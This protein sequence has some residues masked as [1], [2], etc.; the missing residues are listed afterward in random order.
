MFDHVSATFRHSIPPS[1]KHIR[2]PDDDDAASS[3]DSSTHDEDDHRDE[4]PKQSKPKSSKEKSNAADDDES[5]DQ[6]HT[7]KKRAAARQRSWE[8]IG[9]WE[10]CDST[11]DEISGYISQQLIQFN[12]SAG[13]PV[14]KGTHRDRKSL[15]GDFQV[16]RN[17]P[18]MKGMIDNTVLACPYR[19]RSGCQCEV[20]I[21]KNA[22]HVVMSITNAH[23]LADHENESA[24]FLSQ[25]QKAF[26]AAAVKIAPMQT[27]SQLLQNIQDSPTK[28]IDRTLKKSV[29]RQIRKER[30]S[31][32]TVMLEGIEVNNTLGSLSQLSMELW[33]GTA[34]S[35][36]KRGFLYLHYILHYI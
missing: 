14:F 6:S 18:S 21:V 9:R 13:I 7:K 3:A 8:E 26:I 35:Q 16:K 28:A 29:A 12:A 10:R 31:L 4:V 36:H 11:E 22:T 19:D 20:R 5:A 23:S 32:T 1:R 17:W 34:L 24:K 30:Q 27:A 2:M 25:K 15:Y 33:F